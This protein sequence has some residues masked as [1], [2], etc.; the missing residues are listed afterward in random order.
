MKRV[1][2]QKL[3]TM[4]NIVVIGSSNTDM[5]IKSAVLPRPGETVTGGEFFLAAGG[6]GANQAVAAAR[7]GGTVTFIAK[8]GNDSF[9][10]H[11]I[12]GYIKEGINTAHIGR[13]PDL[14]TGIALILVDQKGEN[15]ISVASGA[16]AQWSDAD[17]SRVRSIIEQA[18]IV[19]MQLEIPL[20][21][22]ERV[23]QI[24]AE[25]NVPVLLDPA[26]AVPL[27]EGLL[28]N[29]TYIK[30]NEHEAETVSGIKVVDEASAIQA[31][32]QLLE[33]GVRK[34]VVITLGAK[35]ALL[36]ERGGK[37]QLVPAP[38]VQ[39]ADSTAAGDAFTGALAWQLNEGRGLL[40]A[41]RIANHVAALSTQRMGAQPS[42]PDRK[43]LDD[44]LS[45]GTT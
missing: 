5:V 40:E 43:E 33:L 42:L 38:T 7:L 20:N 21:V 12:E 29:V 19:V 1:Y 45:G 26:P 22:V 11:A 15:L 36:L 17:L 9:G 23:A 14:A 41:V 6:K 35:G 24:A 30:P 4:K 31:A 10:D 25:A 27:P 44:Y 39:V 37:P 16:N 34:A 13:E 8:V 2:S 3:K 18:G 32:Q 28:R